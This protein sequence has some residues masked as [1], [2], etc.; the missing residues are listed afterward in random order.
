MMKMPVV[1]RSQ[2]RTGGEAPLPLRRA[3]AV[4]RPGC[5]ESLSGRLPHW[6]SGRAGLLPA[7]ECREAWPAVL[8]CHC[9]GQVSKN[10]TVASLPDIGCQEHGEISL[11]EWLRMFHAANMKRKLK[12]S[13]AP[14]WL[15]S[16]CRTM[17]CSFA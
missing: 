11:D 1:L 6:R 8:H 13:G 2:Q 16:K 3:T 14:Q 9:A 10:C 15:E 7:S 5:K 12:D 17:T 4:T